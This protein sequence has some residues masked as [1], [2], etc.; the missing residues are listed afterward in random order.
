MIQLIDEFGARIFI[1][2][3]A[4]KYYRENIGGIYAKQHKNAKLELVLIDGS[5]IYVKNT[6]D[7]IINLFSQNLNNGT[8]GE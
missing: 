3:S 2:I 8:V 5:T 6:I 1:S 7:E 4:I